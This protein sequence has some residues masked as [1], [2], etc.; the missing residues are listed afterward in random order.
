MPE[1]LGILGGTFD[2]V[3]VGHLRIAEEAVDQLCLDGLFFIPAAIPPHKVDRVTQP[4]EH[5]LAMLKLAVADNP[6]FGVSSIEQERPG[7]SF[8]VATLRRMHAEASRCVEFYFLVGMDGFLEL[9]SWWHYREL[10]QLAR[11]VVLERPGC[12]E[13]DILEMLKKGVS[14]LYEAAL[15]GSSFLHPHLLPVHGL[16]NTRLEISSTEIRRLCAAG[17]SIRYLVPPDVLRYIS[18][19]ALYRSHVPSDGAA[20]GGECDPRDESRVLGQNGH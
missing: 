19:Y 9:D 6:R 12:R 5:R 16:R 7:R 2:P 18:H 11:I 20:A 1:R 4:F 13:P 15:D 10:F 8:T 3:H 14:P 17:R